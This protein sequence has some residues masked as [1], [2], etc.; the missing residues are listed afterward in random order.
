MVA[1]ADSVAPRPRR[2]LK[3]AGI[4]LAVL[5]VLGVLGVLS[6]VGGFYA[7]KAYY[8]PKL[9][10][11]TGVEDLALQVPLRVYT[12]DGKLMQEF[13]AERRKPLRY[14]QLPQILVQA[15]LAAEDDRYFDHPGVDYQG[16][17][18]AAWVL[19]VTGEKQQGGS[20]ITMQLARN[21]FLTNE[22]TYE[23]KIK[24]IFLALKIEEALSKEEIFSR[25]VNKIFLGNRAYGVGA[26]AEVYYAAEIT[27]ISLSQAAMIAG[28]PK[29][30]SAYNPIANP[31]RALLRRN[32]VLRRMRELGY[33][34]SEQFQQASSEGI[35]AQL[36]RNVGEVDAGYVAEMVRAEMVRRHGDDA[37]TGGYAVTTT[38]DSRE[39]AAANAALRNALVEYDWRQSYR[40]PESRVAEA[41]QVSDGDANLDTTTTLPQ[42]VR[43]QE[44]MRALP[45]IDGLPVA[46]VL[47][48][49][50][51]ALTIRLLDG[52]EMSLGEPALEW[53]QLDDANRPKP[54]DIV[55]IAQAR[56]DEGEAFWKLAQLP[57]AQGAMV[58]LAPQD[59]A[60]RALVGG[61]DFYMGKF[62]R[63]MQAKRQ[64]GSAFKPFLYSAALANGRTPA[65]V[66]NDAPVVFDDAALEDTWRPENYTGRF[67]GPTRLRTALTHSRNLVSI[68]L[69][70]SL[71][72]DTARSHIE[73]FGFSRDVMPR[74]LSLALGTALV[75]PLELARGYGVFA[76][77]GFLVEPYFIQ[78]IRN[79]TGELLEVA[80]PH[81]ACD[82]CE[83]EAPV[84]PV[85][86]AGP[87]LDAQQDEQ[88]E[89]E[90]LTPAPRVLDA[91]NAWLTTSMM[92]DVINA[93]TARR[94]KSL[95]RSDLA[96]KTGTTNEEKD[97]WFAGFNANRVA[98]AWVGYDQLQPLGRG[99]GGGRAALPVWIDY[100]R[101]AL[102]GTKPAQLERPDGLVTVR[103]DPETGEL[104][105]Y[106]TQG[107]VFETFQ[108]DLA[109][110]AQAT[111]N[112]YG[113]YD[114]FDGYSNGN[115]SRDEVETVEDLF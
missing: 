115:T 52:S 73:Q 45:Q 66:I 109:P 14:D 84:V 102:D 28:L 47:T 62:N 82:D 110:Q 106:A 16:L 40:G 61:F 72:I 36:A 68:R 96:G 5:L 79:A 104:A 17:L 7:L 100:M 2:R 42:A 22:R 99:E 98:V 71:G 90:Y 93:G 107:A 21:F 12:A 46:L 70:R 97:A 69:L 19:A 113:G 63:A 25:Y 95:G 85:A 60:I 64:P 58:S 76:N 53:A 26:A 44:A 41:A 75:S 51:K 56:N 18:R 1:E 54:G 39:Q 59:G 83:I 11:F 114:Q 91:V 92:Q 108:A 24:E 38:I 78:E 8:G 57:A 30:P 89:P 31:E 4:V 37:Y 111:G 15:F 23:R 67:Y 48:S 32:Y 49:E 34:T 103:I 33:I 88:I 9:P 29:A 112:G 77:G 50:P 6:A 94:A 105:N 87:I 80:K 65:T 20:T 3:I 101:A 55:R 86:D 13:G 81:P 27:D 35:S 74:D 10:D 43:E